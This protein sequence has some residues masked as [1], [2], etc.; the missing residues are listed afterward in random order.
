MD[1]AQVK[2]SDFLVGRRMKK[3]RVGI[4]KSG[5]KSEGF[6]RAILPEGVV[7]S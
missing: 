7:V 3:L 1:R 6:V 4:L 2:T 5:A